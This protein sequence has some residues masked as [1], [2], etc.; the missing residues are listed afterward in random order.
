MIPED[1]DPRRVYCSDPHAL[2]AR[3]RR[4]RRKVTEATP[5]LITAVQCPVDGTYFAVDLHSKRERHG[6]KYDCSSCREIARQLRE[7]DREMKEKSE[8]NDAADA[9]MVARVGKT[10]AK[11]A[12]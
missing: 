12:R 9:I 7:H 10:A 6:K 2:L 5:F 4:H 11:I 3:V 1:A 8:K